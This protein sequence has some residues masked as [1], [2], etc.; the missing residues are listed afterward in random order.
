MYRPQGL[1]SLIGQK[2]LK[3]SLKVCIDASNKKQI[4]CPHMLLQGPPGLG[5]TT[6]AKIVA[7]ETKSNLIEINGATVSEPQSIVKAFME[8]QEKDIIFIDEIHSLPKKLAELLYMPLEDNQLL[9]QH[10]ERGKEHRTI[11]LPISKF[12][13][14]G[15]TTNVGKVP[16]PLVNRLNL[17]FFLDYYSEPDVEQI[18]K[19]AA[20][21]TNFR[22]DKAGAAALAKRCKGIPRIAN[23]YLRWVENYCVSNGQDKATEDI[24]QAACDLYGVDEIGLDRNDHAYLDALKTTGEPMGLNT[25]SSITNIPTTTIEEQIEPYLMRKNLIEKTK[26]GRQVKSDSDNLSK[27]KLLK[28]LM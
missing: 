12:C 26:S 25:I 20:E 28:G 3:Q 5:K 4:P 27:L 15:A 19:Q 23:N 16:Q 11:S 9:I 7:H 2:Q 17:Q 21:K 1:D 10:K 18:I 14:I 6:I 24:V 22:I 8:L 13:M